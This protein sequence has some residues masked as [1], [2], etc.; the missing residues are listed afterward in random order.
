MTRLPRFSPD[1]LDDAQRA[2]YG[3]VTG[4]RRASGPQAFPLTD[5]AGALRGPFNAMLLSPPVGGALQA[6]G[7]AVRYASVLGDRARELAILAVAAHEDSA[8]E[9]AAHE[10]VG[11]RAGLDESELAAV[12]A[13]SEPATL[14]DQERITLRTARALL[15][16]RT[17]DDAGYA[18]AVGVLGERALFELTTLVGYYAT[19]ALQL[20]VFAAE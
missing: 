3:A 13:G 15:R 14:S 12:R 6:V 20:R 19:L 1:D 9:R 8:F 2:V 17:L 18:A 4:G 5:D 10:A 16:D 7:E 11:R